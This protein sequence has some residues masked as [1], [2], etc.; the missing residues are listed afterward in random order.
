MNGRFLL[1]TNIII[2]LFAKDSF[3]PD[4][5][6]KAKEVFIPNIVLGEL[7]Y[8]AHKSA[9]VD[10]NVTKIDELAEN[11]ALLPYDLETAKN[12]GITKNLLKIRGKPIPENDIWIAAVAK[13]YQL[14]LVSRDAHFREVEEISIQTW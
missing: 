9:H 7:Y 12:Y 11:S 4:H 1:D 10:E 6:I 5:L 2:A 13:Q 3:V 14:I 8:G